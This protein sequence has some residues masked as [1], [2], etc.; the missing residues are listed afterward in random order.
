MQALILNI[1]NLIYDKWISRIDQKSRE[2]IVGFIF[3]LLALFFP[4]YHSYE[5]EYI[6]YTQTQ[7]HIA[8][9]ILLFAA[10]LLS[11]NGKLEQVRWN[12]LLMVPLLLTGLGIVISGLLHPLPSGYFVFGL[13][14]LLVYPCIYFIWINR[15]DYECLFDIIAISNVIV[16]LCY[17]V[18]T[19][20]VF[21]VLENPIVVGRVRGTLAN[22]SKFSMLGMVLACCALY[23]LYRKWESRPARVFYL[24]AAGVGLLNLFLGMSRAAILGTFFGILGLLVFTYHNR[25]ASRKWIRRILCIGCILLAIGL[26]LLFVVH[27][28]GDAHLGSDSTDVNVLERFSLEG[29]DPNTYSSGRIEIWAGYYD[30]NEKL[31]LLQRWLS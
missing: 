2:L 25:P 3:V 20:L 5:F 19:Y 10:A 12:I 4:L 8:A 9:A 30:G 22:S 6:L 26:L 29:K 21:P 23:L 27:R 13:M 31:V 18:Y 15:G 24:I 7:Q 28:G 14:L 11:I 16:G 1:L 17:S